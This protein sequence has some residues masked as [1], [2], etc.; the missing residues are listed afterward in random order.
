MDA[1]KASGIELI[2]DSG[3]LDPRVF[4]PV[5]KHSHSN[6]N[7]PL[8][9]LYLEDRNNWPSRTSALFDG[10]YYLSQNADVRNAGVNPML[11]YIKKGYFEGR[12]PSPLVDIN[13]ILQ[14]IATAD[15]S[16]R[17]RDMAVASRKILSNY[18]GIRELLIETGCDPSVFFSNSFY[19]EANLGLVSE[20]DLIPI[21]D[22]FRRRGRAPGPNCFLE[23]TPLASFNFYMKRHPDLVAASV[24]PLRH[25]LLY[26]LQ[27]GRRFNMVDTVSAE[28]LNNSATLFADDSMKM[29]AGILRSSDG[30]MHLPG[31]F[32]PTPYANRSIPALS[33]VAR[34]GRRSAFVGVVLYKNTEDEIRRLQQSIENEI[35]IG[36][37]GGYGI[38][39][40]YMANDGD[41]ER[42]RAL[43]GAR[44]VA[45]PNSENIGFGKAHNLLMQECFESER[46]YIGANPDG[47]FVPGC[48]RALVDFNDFFDGHGLIEAAALPIDHPKWHDPLTFDSQWVSGACFGLSKWIWEK[49]KGF[50]EKIHLYCEDVDLSWRVRLLG[51]KL[52]VCPTARFMHDVTPRF[53]NEESDSVSIERRKSMLKGAY[54]LARKWGATERAEILLTRLSQNL[55]P[56]EVEELTEPDVELDGAVVGNIA[57]FRHDRFAPSRFWK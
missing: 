21:E 12:S 10:G 41:V 55:E 18:G 50:D 30:Q 34:E 42:Y 25:L 5:D 39:Y 16:L 54:Y 51:G 3:L 27:E 38:Q 47:Y 48:I 15:R 32:W 19:R 28:F 31:P 22:Y 43:L 33:H 35:E 44:V 1:K 57:D 14:Q 56:F 6:A 37:A 40:K 7:I 46:L 26:G 8:E 52:K 49:T 24:V 29:L 11:H 36:T 9:Q 45:S 53:S 2:H 4:S 23:C 20:S 17:E 13:F